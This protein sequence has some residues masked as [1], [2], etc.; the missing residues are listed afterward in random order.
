MRWR[1]TCPD[2]LFGSKRW[3][4]RAASI[5]RPPNGG[6]TRR[7]VTMLRTGDDYRESIRDGREVWINGEQVADVPSHPALE[8]IVD[9]PDRIYDMAHE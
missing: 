6:R 3:L 7:K 2:R 8:P 4:E 5:S 9:V 1:T